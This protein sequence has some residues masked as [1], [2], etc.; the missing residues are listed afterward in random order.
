M[1]ISLLLELESQ[2]CRGIYALRRQYHVHEPFVISLYRRFVPAHSNFKLFARKLPHIAATY[3]PF[4][5]EFHNP[6]YVVGTDRMQVKLGVRSKELK[7]L[8]RDF[9][10]HLADALVFENISRN[11]RAA[12]MVGEKFS[13]VLTLRHDME[14]NPKSYNKSCQVSVKS[15]I[16]DIGEADRVL[17]ELAKI[18]LKSLGNLRVIGLRLLWDQDTAQHSK[19]PSQVFGELIPF[20]RKS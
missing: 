3:A 11:E 4:D 7:A 14:A 16:N 12:A 1:P 6:H 20:G 8:R 9:Q 5:L 17:N 18:N 19:N 15:K 13:P 10:T 2:S